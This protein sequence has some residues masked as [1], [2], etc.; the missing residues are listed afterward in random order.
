M[1]NVG[2]CHQCGGMGV[3]EGFL[4]W[5]SRR[6]RHMAIFR[7]NKCEARWIFRGGERWVPEGGWVDGL[8]DWHPLGC[9]EVIGEEEE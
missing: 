6:D 2:D 3:A 9:M 7:C 8:P 5:G 1:M 4:N